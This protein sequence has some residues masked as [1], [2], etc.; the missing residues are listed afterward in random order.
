MSSVIKGLLVLLSLGA[1]FAQGPVV[2]SVGNGFIATAG[3]SLGAYA[4]IYGNNFGTDKTAVAVT[5]G[6]KKAYM[7]ASSTRR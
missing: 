3:V 4:A 1:A 7:L 5:V 2:T 6:G